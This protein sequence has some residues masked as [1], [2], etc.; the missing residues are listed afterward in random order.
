[1]SKWHI[2]SWRGNSVSSVSALYASGSKRVLW[3]IISWRTF[4]ADSRSASCR[5][6]MKEL[7]LNTGEQL[8]GALPRSIVVK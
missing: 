8:P 2:V 5:L 6:L 4:P 3:H 7:A 1:M